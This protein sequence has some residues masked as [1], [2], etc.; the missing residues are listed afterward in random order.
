MKILFLSSSA[1]LSCRSSLISNKV[2]H[3]GIDLW[4][5][6][7]I[8]YDH[9]DRVTRQAIDHAAGGRLLDHIAEVSWKLIED[10]TLYDNESLFDP[11]DLAKPVK[12]IYLPQDVPSTSDRRLVELKTR[13]QYLLEAHIAPVTPT[14]V[15]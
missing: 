1:A 11:R 3:H 14:K 10:L 15:N 5:Q 9:V 8:F 4:L 12:A 13:I 6:V 7:Q 2:P